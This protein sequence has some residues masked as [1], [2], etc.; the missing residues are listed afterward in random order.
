MHATSPT[1]RQVEPILQF[2]SKR[3]LR[4]ARTALLLQEESQQQRPIWLHFAAGHHFPSLKKEA[5]RGRKEAK[6]IFPH[7][8]ADLYQKAHVKTSGQDP[9]I[10]PLAPL[11]Y[12]RLEFAEVAEEGTQHIKSREKCSTKRIG[13]ER[14]TNGLAEKMDLLLKGLEDHRKETREAFR[15]LHRNQLEIA[16]A[17][18]ITL[19]TVSPSYFTESYPATPADILSSSKKGKRMMTAPKDDEEV[20]KEEC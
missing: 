2:M 14:D 19:S 12:G 8:I 15:F 3:N 5:M 11:N 1:Q 18:H 20:D 9:I 16:E 6:M 7:V 4:N 10:R 17:G 13:T